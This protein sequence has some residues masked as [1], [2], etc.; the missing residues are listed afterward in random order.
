M[1]IIDAH[2][3][4]NFIGYT[5]D[6]AVANMDEQGIDKA[7]L[8]SW[9]APWDEIDPVMYRR[10]FPPHLNDIPFSVSSKQP[11]LHPDRFIIGYCRA[12]ER[13]MH[14]INL[15]MP[16]AATVSKSAES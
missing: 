6:R 3:H 13:Q 11:R 1:K 16:S 7:W 15:N 14:W 9:E 4:V 12:R 2:N 8:L 5:N 10:A